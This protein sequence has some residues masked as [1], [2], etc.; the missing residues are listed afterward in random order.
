M[1][2]VNRN[3]PVTFQ[4][5]DMF[6]AEDERFM[7]V[8]I[9]LMHTGINR[10]N[11]DFSKEVIEEAIPTLANTPILGYL[12][13]NSDGNLDFSDHRE[14]L[15][16]ED[17]KFKMKYKGQAFGVIPED[18]NAQFE[19]RVCDDGVE[20]EFLTVEGILWTKW[21]DPIELMTE[22]GVKGQSM[23][24][25]DNPIEGE[26]YQKGRAKVFR[27]SK[28]AFFGACILGDGVTPAMHDASIETNFTATLHSEIQ[29][30]MEA[31]KL[32]SQQ[33]LN[34]D[35]NT[36]K[37]GEQMPFAETLAKYNTTEVELANKGINLTQFSSVED[38]ESKLDEILGDV[39]NSGAADMS[40]DGD[41]STVA[42]NFTAEG[43]HTPTDPETPATDFALSGNQL[44][45]ELYR[46]LA[47]FK[48]E[49]RWGYQSQC[50]YYVDY[51]PD[52]NIVIVYDWDDEWYLGLT[53]AVNGNSVEID[54][55]SGVRYVS[56]WVKFSPVTKDPETEGTLVEDDE[57]NNAPTQMSLVPKSFHEYIIGNEKQAVEKQFADSN[58]N[59][60]RT[61]LDAM[62][63]KYETVASELRQFKEA[64]HSEKADK[65]FTQ[66]ANSLTEEDVA[67][68]KENI[69]SYSLE[70][71]EEKLLA[72][73]A[74]KSLNFSANKPKEEEKPLA[75]FSF[76]SQSEAPTSEYDHIFKRFLP[77]A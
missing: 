26:W 2:D 62:K 50:F 57:D 37:E 75:K 48:E 63:T 51:L 35:V 10:N 52:E 17:G 19:M 33:R 66:F 43:T 25:A 67:D 24:L 68:L 14:V 11:S 41:Q 70:T 12:E 6:E 30:K 56:Q 15:V 65:L 42:D 36:T 76:P 46:E 27:F 58:V 38:L 54:Y 44:V 31:Y 61:E 69:H 71:L 40:L 21:D 45:N 73:F 59:V 49:D 34:D 8:K 47:E 18:N 29:S 77:N 22:F 7:R 74:K 60:I 23:E 4:K 64:E 1:L 20:R 53:Y 55:N 72:R 32:A 28:F 13:E 9:W 5:L 16:K 3:V 39:N